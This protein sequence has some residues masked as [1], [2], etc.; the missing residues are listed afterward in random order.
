MKRLM[1]LILCVLLSACAKVP[2]SDYV[3]S[4]E[5]TLG[6][7]HTDTDY[8]PHNDDTVEEPLSDFNYALPD[9]SAHGE[10]YAD[11]EMYITEPGGSEDAV[12]GQTD[13][14]LGDRTSRLERQRVGWRKRR[15][16]GV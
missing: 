6:E 3:P 15:Y 13:A 16:L 11:E 8:V 10:T 1:P 9:Y 4:S 12:F 14:C 2:D 5:N 7:I